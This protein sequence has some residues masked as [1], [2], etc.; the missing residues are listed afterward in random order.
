MA[1]LKAA[2]LS[3]GDGGVVDDEGLSLPQIDDFR[4]A[5]IGCTEP[6]ERPA[7]LSAQDKLT[8]DILHGAPVPKTLEDAR[9]LHRSLGKGPKNK[10]AQGQYDRAWN[11]LFE[12]AGNKVISDLKRS[13]A[14][15]FVSRLVE[16]G[17]SA[18]TIR[19]YVAQISPVLKLAIREFELDCSNPFE[20]LVIPN[21]D[22]DQRNERLPYSE[23]ELRV[24]QA[25]CRR[26]DDPR[27]W[28]IAALSDTGA[29][30]REFQGMEQADVF[31]M[32]L[33]PMFISGQTAHGG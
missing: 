29:R 32:L 10:V 21:K 2:G 5:L 20:T 16:S 3:P 4:E 24:I 15:E 27:R 30:L 26:M 31:S 14:N 1:R 28:L 22:D 13:D 33:F 6:G 18:D 17:V 7:P 19:K 8:L 25:A 9:E 11:L 23:D 12:I